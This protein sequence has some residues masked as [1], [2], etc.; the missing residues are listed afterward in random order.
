MDAVDVVV[1]AVQLQHSLKAWSA[2]FPDQGHIE[3]LHSASAELRHARNQEGFC[4]QTG[5][6][7]VEL[8]VP[9]AGECRVVEV[10]APGG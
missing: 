4:V 3:G 9:A 5:R 10:R 7:A 1:E 6:S 2:S 8:V